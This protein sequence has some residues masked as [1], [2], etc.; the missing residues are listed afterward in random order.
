[1]TTMKSTRVFVISAALLVAACS[2]GT[3]EVAGSAPVS[4]PAAASEIVATTSGLAKQQLPSVPPIF[5]F[6]P[7]TG[8]STWPDGDRYEA[9]GLRIGDW[10][11]GEQIAAGDL[12]VVVD[13][14]SVG[15][16]GVNSSKGAW[17]HVP[18]EGQDFP[19]M[20]IAQD[21]IVETVAVV[22]ARVGEVPGRKQPADPRTASSNM[23]AV[24]PPPPEVGSRFTMSVPGGN[25]TLEIPDDQWDAAQQEAYGYWFDET[26][27]PHDHG[28]DFVP[29]PNDEPEPTTWDNTPNPG[30]IKMAREPGM[31]VTEGHRYLLILNGQERR[32]LEGNAEFTWRP[33]F[34]F[35]L[36]QLE[37]DADLGVFRTPEEKATTATELLEATE[38]AVDLERY[39]AITTFYL[40]SLRSLLGIGT[41]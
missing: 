18:H 10:T 2:P 9:L 28:P 11:L 36:T 39:P 41:Q 7:G 38:A 5:D 34:T 17:W 37:V 31:V 19:G 3:A 35:E 21:V 25:V 4:T 13:I 6:T 27:T 29:D 33:T 16:A 30:T 20:D 8:E 23:I 24:V 14:I 32:F 22:K 12:V 1:M 40:D 15:P 26:F